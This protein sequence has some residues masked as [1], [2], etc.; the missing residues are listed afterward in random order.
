MVWAGTGGDTE[1]MMRGLWAA[2][3]V[4]DHTLP[5]LHLI[6]A[7]PPISMAFHTC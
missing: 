2:P 7:L 4:Q 5:V 6:H 1:E 3:A